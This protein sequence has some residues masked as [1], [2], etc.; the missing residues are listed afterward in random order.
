VLISWVAAQ[1][2]EN[3]ARNNPAVNVN[4]MAMMGMNGMM[5]QPMMGGGMMGQVCQDCTFSHCLCI[6]PRLSFP[7]PLLVCLRYEVF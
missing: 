2:Q 5:G 3:A 1:V 4:P 6:T 7:L